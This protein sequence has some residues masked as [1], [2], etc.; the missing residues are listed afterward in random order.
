MVLFDP[1]WPT[2]VSQ[3]QAQRVARTL[4]GQFQK[5][6][7]AKFAGT[8]FSEVRCRGRG[9]GKHPR[10][11]GA[12]KQL[13]AAHPKSAQTSISRPLPCNG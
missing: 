3:I 8:E 2:Y 5:E 10:P 6:C 11:S 13:S 1:F 12:T 4:F 7:S 9:E